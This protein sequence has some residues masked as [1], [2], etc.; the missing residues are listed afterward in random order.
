MILVWAALA[1]A[2]KDGCGTL[3]V[4]AQ[5][6][7]RAVLAGLLDA[8]GD[9]AQVLVVLFGAGQ[10]IE[11]GMTGMSVAVLVTIMLTSFAGTVLWTRLGTRWMPER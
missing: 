4:I 3:L 7:G 11:H 5:A 9:L 6:R 1:M 10:I 8:A 2:L